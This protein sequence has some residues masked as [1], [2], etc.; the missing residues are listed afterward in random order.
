MSSGLSWN[1]VKSYRGASS[2][3]ESITEMV[4][5]TERPACVLVSLHMAIEGRA[6]GR[7]RSNDNPI[8]PSITQKPSKGIAKPNIFASGCRKLFSLFS[9]HARR[10][11]VTTYMLRNQGVHHG[12]NYSA[13]PVNALRRLD[14][15]NSVHYQ[16]TTQQF[17]FYV[18]STVAIAFV[19]SAI[20][21]SSAFMEDCR[22]RKA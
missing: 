10:T 20:L 21:I 18:R 22:C 11:R 2:K 14:S 13:T 17:L 16:K 4:I 1:V 7:G 9:L 6:K 8:A 3:Q 12:N 15:G 5:K 19:P